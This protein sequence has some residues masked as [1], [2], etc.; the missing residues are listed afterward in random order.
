[1]KSKRMTHAC[2][3]CGYEESSHKN[4]DAWRCTKCN[5]YVMSY[6]SNNETRGERRVRFEGK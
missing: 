4:P 5:G 2:L 1:M 6:E 3:E